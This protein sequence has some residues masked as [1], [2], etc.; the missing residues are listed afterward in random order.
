MYDHG[1]TAGACQEPACSQ[2]PYG[3][4]GCTAVTTY[5]Y[6]GGLSCGVVPCRPLHTADRTTLLA[7]PCVWRAPGQPLRNIQHSII[8]SRF[9]LEYLCEYVDQDFPYTVR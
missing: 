3:T 5:C 6:Q 1:T 8:A 4:F 7:R 2:V 9:Y